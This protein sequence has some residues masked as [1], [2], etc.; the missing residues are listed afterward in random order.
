MLE[1]ETATPIEI[2]SGSSAEVQAASNWK[3][4]LF[5]LAETQK[6]L[7]GSLKDL[8]SDVESVFA[9]D[10]TLTA[11]EKRKWWGGCSVPAK[12]AEELLRTLQITV[13]VACFLA[14]TQPA[15]ISFALRRLKNEQAIIALLPR[16]D[17]VLLTL[18]S[19]DFSRDIAAH[20]LWFA[21]GDQWPAQ[22]SQ[23]FRLNPGLP[24]PQQF[25]RTALLSDDSSAPMIVTA[26]K[27]FAD[28]SAPKAQ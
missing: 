2:E 24:I 3:S 12:A 8:S 10:G 25:I 5:A 4:N 15:Q 13:S 9:R 28:N 16:F 22:M 19:H 18:R 1:L 27:I 6:E 23:L 11:L 14:P 7:A 17:D 21:V 20:R 26:Q